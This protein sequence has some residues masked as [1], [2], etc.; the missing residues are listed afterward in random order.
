MMD[1]NKIY[2]KSYY[3]DQYQKSEQI[4]WDNGQL[5]YG[6]QCAALSYLFGL[7]DFEAIRNKF[8]FKDNGLG[9]DPVIG[10]KSQIEKIKEIQ[11]IWG[12]NPQYVVEVGAGRCELSFVLSDMG[13]KTTAIE[14]ASCV[15]ELIPKTIE[16]LNIRPTENFKL[17]NKKLED[18][19]DDLGDFDA[20]LF[21]ESLE[22]LE[23][24]EFEN[25]F[26]KIKSILSKNS[27]L[28]IVVN[29][30]QYHPLETNSIDHIMKIDDDFFDRISTEAKSVLYRNGSHL[31]LQF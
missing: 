6:D 12:G 25:V 7:Y 8:G 30:I 20:M 28:F 10:V 19:I 31:V 2:N 27:G 18:C 1:I 9:T 29:W 16:K 21:V 3:L 11:E 14:P 22:H 23:Q 4:A 24:E 26:P 15:F 13:V 17:I 5:R